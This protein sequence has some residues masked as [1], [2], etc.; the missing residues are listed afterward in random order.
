MSNS[1]F[2]WLYRHRILAISSVN[3]SILVTLTVLVGIAL[4]TPETPQASAMSRAGRA[5]EEARDNRAAPS[6]RV[7]L[8]APRRNPRRIR[9]RGPKYLDARLLET[10]DA[11]PG[12]AREPSS[13]QAS[14][15]RVINSPPKR[16]SVRV[17]QDALPPPRGIETADDYGPWHAQQA[18]ENVLA[19]LPPGHPLRRQQEEY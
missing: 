2:K 1:C 17:N 18:G 6:H 3:A 8:Q 4:F 12:A 13:P 15:F 5:G 9:V 10:G 16:T 7:S 14:S 19:P 11:R